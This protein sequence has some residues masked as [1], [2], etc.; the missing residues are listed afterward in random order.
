M[1]VDALSHT[2][3]LSQSLTQ[4]V[5]HNGDPHDLDACDDHVEFLQN[6]PTPPPSYFCERVTFRD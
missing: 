6:T 2:Y 5:R 1:A 4:L 3:S